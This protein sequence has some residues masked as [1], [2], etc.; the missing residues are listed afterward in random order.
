MVFVVWS[1]SLGA[2]MF[3]TTRP[4]RVPTTP[5]NA[6]G[7]FLPYTSGRLTLDPISLNNSG[8][9]LLIDRVKANRR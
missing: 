1:S 6:N 4:L 2:R 7:I 8:W 5:S 9:D 3:I